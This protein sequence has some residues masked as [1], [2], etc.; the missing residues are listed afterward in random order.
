MEIERP[1][2][3]LRPRKEKKIIPMGVFSIE[4]LKQER[5]KFQKQI[6]EIEQALT[7]KETPIEEID[8]NQP[9][10]PIF[11]RCRAYGNTL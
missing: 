10:G 11:I 1:T 4:R 8:V 2:D 7:E 9:P 6:R 3:E 5:I